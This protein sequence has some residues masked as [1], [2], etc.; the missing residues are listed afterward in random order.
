MMVAVR[1]NTLVLPKLDF[2]DDIAATGTFLEEPV[3]NVAFLATL[4]L[5]YRF[6]ENR[7]GIRRA[8]RSRHERSA[9]PL[10]SKCAHIRSRSSRLSGRRQ[11]KAPASL[12][13]P[14]FF[15]NERR[16]VNFASV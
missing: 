6:L 14:R 11:S 16:H 9:R 1:A 4:F 10:F 5:D 3:R 13:R 15:V 7:H 2:V 12:A 8:R